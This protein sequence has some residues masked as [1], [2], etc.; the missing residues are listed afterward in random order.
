VLWVEEIQSDWAES[1]RKGTTEERGPFVQDTRLWT[2]LAIKK[3]IR[4]AAEKNVDKVAFVKPSQAVN[5][6]GR[7]KN[8]ADTYYG[9]IVPSVLKNVLNKL[10]GPQLETI[11]MRPGRKPT[12]ADKQKFVKLYK[13][14]GKAKG[15][16]KKAGD[17]PFYQYVNFDKLN[18]LLN[19]Y[20]AIL[21]KEAPGIKVEF[22]NGAVKVSLK[23]E[24]AYTNV[25]MGVSY[26]EL[27]KDYQQAQEL[28]PLL[29]KTKRLAEAVVQDHSII[30]KDP[31]I[32]NKIIKNLKN[33]A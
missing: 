16:L 10:D 21:M 31:K 9:V 1:L 8:A 22:S 28:K 15:K 3:I 12:E 5:V 23:Q 2:K 32:R 17:K 33:C 4:I 27:K 18:T 30:M 19:T 14:L 24:E 7:S 11:D 26:A 29:E 6:H 25:A 20:A 13:E